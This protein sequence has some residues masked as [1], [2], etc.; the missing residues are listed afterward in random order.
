MIIV[1]LVQIEAVQ[2]VGHRTIVE[3][4]FRHWGSNAATIVRSVVSL[5]LLIVAV[6]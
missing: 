3:G 1:A 6:D 5:A 2:I 4:L